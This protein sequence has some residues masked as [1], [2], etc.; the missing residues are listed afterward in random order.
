MSKQV[1]AIGDTGS[2]LV[3]KLGN[4][5][6]E[7]YLGSGGIGYIIQPT[8]AIHTDAW[9]IT[10]NVTYDTFTIL[11]NYDF[12]TNTVTLPSDVKLLFN[13]GVWSNGTIVGSNTVLF[14]YGIQQAF[15][16]DLAFSGTWKTHGVCPEYY[17]AITN[18]NTGIF[19]NDCS[20][21]I[22]VCLDSIFNV[23]LNAGFYYISTGLIVT[24]PKVVSCIQGIITGYNEGI[25]TIADHTRIYTDQNID[26]FHI[27]TSGFYLLG[28]PVLDMKAV[29]APTNWGIKFNTNYFLIRGK[30]EASIIGNYTV[31]NTAVGAGSIG[32]GF[33]DDGTI[34]WGAAYQQEFHLKLFNLKAGIYSPAFIPGRPYQLVGQ[35]QWWVDFE[36]CKQALDLESGTFLYINGMSQAVS[37]LHAGEASLPAVYLNVNTC[38][39]DLDLVDY[40]APGTNTDYIHVYSDGIEFIGKSVWLN[41]QGLIEYFNTAQEYRKIERSPYPNIRIKDGTQELG[42]IYN[43]FA[44]IN[45]DWSIDKYD[46]T[47]YDYDANLSESVGQ[48]AA[49]AI[50]ITN[51]TELF[52]IRGDATY[53]TFTNAVVKD[54]E[55][56]EIVIDNLNALYTRL[57]SLYYYLFGVDVFNRIQT[58]L[59][60]APGGVPTTVVDN[61]Y[62]VKGALNP[63]LSKLFFPLYG[64]L[65][66]DSLSIQKIIIRFIGCTDINSAILIQSIY[67]SANTLINAPLIDIQGGQT[68]YGTL[69]LTGA[70][71]QTELSGALTDGA[72]TDAEIDSI[73]GTTPAVAGAG[74]KCTIKDT[75]GTAL[76]YL[77]ESDGSD[78]FYSVM[79]KAT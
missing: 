70:L 36:A 48:P 42:Y 1:V 61:Q 69:G 22:Q 17:G 45:A 72:P 2:Q 38:T 79:T 27:K 43:E 47:G 9:W 20:A 21:E 44:Y 30:I 68:I 7:L 23:F 13:G 26:I 64:T 5:F 65:T 18:A 71:L 28:S 34:A 37:C 63:Y 78:W 53:I 46:G 76:I 41:N 29:V 77:V 62:P 8:D 57:Y 40:T 10:M 54:N 52:K 39:I 32:V 67:A 33:Y 75:G 51:P 49:S 66:T 12:G 73:T 25:L 6:D 31:L 14:I 15:D 59:H 3:S 74:W 50:T 60:T 55:F 4:N 56:V 16:T 19:L 35:C 58:I 24:T 11:N